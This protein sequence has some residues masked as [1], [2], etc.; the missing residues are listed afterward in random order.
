MKNVYSW[1]NFSS[2]ARPVRTSFD[3]LNDEIILALDIGTGSLGVALRKAKEVEVLESF[4]FPPLHGSKAKEREKRRMIRTR[5][6]HRFRE[7][8]WDAL[9]ASWGGETLSQRN[10]QNVKS[11]ADHRMNRQFPAKGQEQKYYHGA[12]LSIAAIEGKRLE[13]WQIYKAIRHTIQLRGYELV[14]WAARSDLDN[15]EEVE[16]QGAAA[17]WLA[18]MKERFP[19]NKCLPCY[20]QADRMGLWDA[21]QQKIS[22]ARPLKPSLRY[23]GDRDRRRIYPRRSVEKQLRLLLEYAAK[24]KDVEIEVEKVLYGPSGQPYVRRWSKKW[25]SDLGDQ[26]NP[27]QA[28]R[29]IFGQRYA[30]FDN[31]A[32]SAC[33]CIPQLHAAKRDPDKTDRVETVLEAQLLLQ[34]INFRFTSGEQTGLRLSADLLR[35]FLK[36]RKTADDRWKLNKSILQKFLKSKG[37]DWKL[38]VQH[39]AREFEFKTS[40]RAAFSRHA[41]ELIR[42]LILSGEAPTSFHDKLAARYQNAGVFAMA[43][44]CYDKMG[45]WKGGT[46]TP[47]DIPEGTLLLTEAHLS[48]LKNMGDSWESIH[49]PDSKVKGLSDAVSN[50]LID[51]REAIELLISDQGDPR[52]QHRMRLIMKYVEKYTEHSEKTW[53][54]APD[55]VVVE[56]PREKEFTRDSD[57]SPKE[58]KKANEYIKQIEANEA[59]WAYWEVKRGDLGLLPSFRNTLKAKLLEQQNFRCIYSGRAFSQV[60]DYASAEFEHIV[61]RAQRGTNVLCNLVLSM[62]DVNTEKA[63]MTP[64]EKWGNDPVRWAEIES[65]VQSSQLDRD[66]KAIL[67][68][69]DAKSALRKHQKGDLGGTA[70]ITKSMVLMLKLE[71]SVSLSCLESVVIEYG[72]NV[73]DRRRK[74]HYETTKQAGLDPSADSCWLSK[75]G[76]KDRSQKAH[77]GVDALLATFWNYRQSTMLQ[78]GVDWFNAQVARILPREIIK[79][80]PEFNETI[81]GRL[82]DAK[83]SFFCRWHVD[84]FGMKGTKFDPKTLEKHLKRLPESPL[85]FRLLSAQCADQASW[86]SLC[87]KLAIRRLKRIEGESENDKI[88]RPSGSGRFYAATGKLGCWIYRDGDRIRC[89]DWYPGVPEPTLPPGAMKVEN[90]AWVELSEDYMQQ[91]GGTVRAGVYQIKTIQNGITVVLQP[92]NGESVT[93]NLGVLYMVSF[94]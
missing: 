32:I 15:E 45:R 29:G 53:G 71:R 40:G 64:Y 69:P 42:A 50:R 77:H 20:Y 48:F 65:Y 21:K 10:P 5:D 78:C 57:A 79:N 81:Y 27:E 31:R 61:P 63:D 56:L 82:K 72:H 55:R 86:K 73:S 74:L 25:S 49:L 33:R 62:G 46:S 66:T 24:L 36:S 1:K 93:S 17:D 84:K 94:I 59:E 54:R 90:G 13:D 28:L 4:T 19:E 60:D 7:D 23:R 67:L 18:Q 89:I 34:L 70:W 75:N 35:G 87:E 43:A 9:W 41:A 58:R 51:A 3:E 38:A 88:E 44:D 83:R 47:K 26:S 76:K 2:G 30:R 37:L 14:E 91:R 12:L 39:D 92:Q 8:Q 22:S 11:R 85:K 52:V 80:P 68:S 6:A 16:A